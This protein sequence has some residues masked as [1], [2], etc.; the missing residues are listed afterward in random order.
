[1][2]VAWIDQRCAEVWIASR[3]KM[4]A[5][6]LHIPE[7]LA[8][9]S[10]EVQEWLTPVILQERQYKQPNVML[11]DLVTAWMRQKEVHEWQELKGE[12]DSMIEGRIPLNAQRVQH[13]NN[14]SKRL[15]GSKPDPDILREAPLHG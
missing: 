9:V 10:A 8:G 14:L 3:T 11:E 13:Y 6:T 15:K 1:M 2:P 4:A 7:V 12:I 5:G